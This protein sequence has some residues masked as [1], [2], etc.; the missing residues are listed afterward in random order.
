MFLDP[1]E[2]HRVVCAHAV[3]RNLMEKSD[4]PAAPQTAPGAEARFPY[5]RAAV[6]RFAATVDQDPR[7]L[8]REN[9]T[10][11]LRLAPGPDSIVLSVVLWFLDRQQDGEPASPED[12][13]D[14]GRSEISDL[15]AKI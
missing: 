6:E 12:K 11:V 8:Q 4:A 7:N 3:L 14:A 15:A 1:N 9:F 13:N 10:F 2:L 5:D